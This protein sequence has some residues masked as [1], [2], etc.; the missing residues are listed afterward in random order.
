MVR[1]AELNVRPSA[2][3]TWLRCTAQPRLLR[4]AAASGFIDLDES[5]PAAEKGTA[6]HLYAQQL[7]NYMV[8]GGEG[9]WPELPEGDGTFEV[10]HF[11]E[12][13]LLQHYVAPIV[14]LLDE[15]GPEHY[16]IEYPVPLWYVASHGTVDFWHYDARTFTLHVKDLKFGRYV[17]VEASSYQLRVY[18]TALWLMLKERV[19]IDWI[20]C[21]IVQ[22]L[23]D[24]PTRVT[25]FLPTALQQFRLWVDEHVRSLVNDAPLQYV[26]SENGCAFCKVKAVCG[27]HLNM[28]RKVIIGAEVPSTVELKEKPTVKVTAKRR[29]QYLQRLNEGAR[30]LSDVED[31]VRAMRKAIRSA[32]E[33]DETALKEWKIDNMEVGPWRWTRQRRVKR[34]LVDRGIDLSLVSELLPPK[35]LD[36]AV[37]TYYPDD[38]EVLN[39]TDD[40]RE[41]D[42][43]KVLV[44]PRYSSMLTRR[45]KPK[46]KKGTMNNGQ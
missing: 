12:R 16:G 22:P 42:T 19:R 18:A 9:D 26:V 40:L 41:R 35:K 1:V 44:S 29:Q 38:V 46:A 27:E 17:A 7:L 15:Q 10:T 2:A 31:W 23:Q 43:T 20:E 3:D 33:Q 32:L 11:E 13:L 30:I 36:A 4:R 34:L 37:R 6:A 39:E 8:S 25:K 21:A 45:R 5:S 24:E 28:A 14:E